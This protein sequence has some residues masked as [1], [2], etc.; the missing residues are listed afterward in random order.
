[1]DSFDRSLRTVTA[2]AILLLI[3]ACQDAGL[4]TAPSELRTGLVAYEHAN[5]VGASA[6]ITRS[7]TDLKDVKGPC[8][9]D[10]G[11]G[12]V[13]RD[14]NDCISSIRIAPGWRATVYRDGNL[15][16][17]SLEVAADVPNLQLVAGTCDHDGLN[18][19]ITSI[20]VFAP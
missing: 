9:H 6:H 16:G 18:D 8:E 4:P 1:M 2:A 12:N 10:D 14:W 15:K 11:D 7:L 5:F 19:C 17:Q 13:T 20:R 3:A